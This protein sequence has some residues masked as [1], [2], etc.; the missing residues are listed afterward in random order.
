MNWSGSCA[1]V[2]CGYMFATSPP[3]PLT[4]AIE[5]AICLHLPYF[6]NKEFMSI[7]GKKFTLIQGTLSQSTSRHVYAL[8]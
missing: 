6:P 3:V 4:L 8:F 2:F 7:E 1:F 5:E